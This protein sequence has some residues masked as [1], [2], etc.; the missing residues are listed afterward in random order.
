MEF[1]TVITNIINP[2]CLLMVTT[3]VMVG[4]TFGVIPGLNTPIAMALVLPFTF[5]LGTIPTICLIMGIYMGGVSGGLVTA[6]MLKIPGTAASV[7]T[8]FDGYPM[9]L[10]GEGLNA[11]S[12]G[13]FASFFGGIFSGLTLILF[14]PLLSKLAI[15]FGPWEYFGSSV[16]ALSLVCALSNGKLVK[17]FLSM[18]L[19]LLITTVGMSPIDG[20]ATRFT[21]GNLNIEN[22]FSIIAIV[23]GIFALPEIINTS[24][25]LKDKIVPVE[26]KKRRFYTLSLKEIKKYLGTFV[27]S[28]CIGT[29]IGILPGMGGGPAG[30]IAYAQE[31]RMSKTPEEFGKGTGYGVAASESA[32]NATT[33]GAL[34]PTL[35]L[36]IPGDTT[37]AIILG[38]FSIQGIV[39][40]PLLSINEPILFKSIIFSFFIANIVMFLVQASTIPYMSK[41]IQVPR[42]YLIPIITVFCITGVI[43]INNNIFEVYYTLGFALLGYILDKNDYPIAPLILGAVLGGIVETSLRRSISYYGSFSGCLSRFSVGTLFFVIAL[44]V[45]IVAIAMDMK[46]R[47]QTA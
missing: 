12:I 21:F 36:S 14:T 10:K 17:G 19:G 28:S 31:K 35:A 5:S 42:A 30:M 2:F 6:I 33:G 46:K 7:A 26:I 22:G 23:I 44:I 18:G 39:T 15:S 11:L 45:P 1:L 16:L 32:N 9:A 24:G 8:T 29:V 20:I 43:C 27:R 41:I 40:G 13:T 3:G 34:I 47:K 4:L 38:A 25:R 37:T